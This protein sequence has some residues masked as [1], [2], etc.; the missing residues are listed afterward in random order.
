MRYRGTPKLPRVD[1]DAAIERLTE[2][3]EADG[4]E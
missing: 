4:G 2:S 3:I 1:L